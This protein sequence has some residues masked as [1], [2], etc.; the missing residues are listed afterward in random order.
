MEPRLDMT[1]VL[2]VSLELG[3]KPKSAIYRNRELGKISDATARRGHI[4]LNQR[5]RSAG[6]SEGPLHRAESSRSFEV[7]FDLARRPRS[8][9][10][11]ISG[12]KFAG[13]RRTRLISSWE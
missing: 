10:S 11:R 4:R 1:D 9:E 7:T 2:K 6:V 5:Q 13:I 8:H 3:V 12:L